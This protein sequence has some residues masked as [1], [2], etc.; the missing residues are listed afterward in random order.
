VDLSLNFYNSKSIEKWKLGQKGNLVYLSLA[1][2]L[3]DLETFGDM[4]VLLLYFKV[5]A[6]DENWK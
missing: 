5:G 4:Q 1:I 6:S 2:N 3:P